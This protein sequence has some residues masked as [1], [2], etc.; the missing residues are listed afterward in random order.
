M[1]NIYEI[2]NKLI[3]E[4]KFKFRFYND[5]LDNLELLQYYHN[6]KDDTIEFEFRNVTKEYL[7]EL[8]SLINKDIKG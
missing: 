7:K 2:V 3:K 6:K 5:S 8:K 1:N 4:D